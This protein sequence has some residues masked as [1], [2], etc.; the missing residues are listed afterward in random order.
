MG[1]HHLAAQPRHLLG[2]LARCFV[3]VDDHMGGG[4]PFEFVHVDLLGAADAPDGFHPVFRMDA[5]RR[6]ADDRLLQ[7]QVEQQFGDAGDEGNDAAT[8]AGGA[9]NDT[10]RVEDGEEFEAG[11]AMGRFRSV[12]F[13]KTGTTTRFRGMS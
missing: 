9:M 5:E 4:Q 11:T 12:I 10:R 1:D 6:S 13:R 2:Q 3:D 8:G 7:P